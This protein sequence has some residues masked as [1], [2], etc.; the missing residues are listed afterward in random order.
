MEA[1]TEVGD[2]V[3]FSI[4]SVFLPDP[5]I[6]LAKLALD[7]MVEGTILDFSDSGTVARA[8]VIVDVVRRQTV[9]VP[10][11]KLERI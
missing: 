5:P 8:F 2:R 10:V 6:A 1:N 9:V 3:R 7:S 4:E 11:D